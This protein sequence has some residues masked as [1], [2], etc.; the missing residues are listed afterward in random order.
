MISAVLDACVLYPGSL[1]DFLLHLAADKLVLPFWSEAIRDEWIENLLQKRPKLT[2]ESL[3][4]TRRMMDIHF[5]DSLVQEYEPLIEP[6]RLP[7]P[8]D[9]H[10]LAAAI[11]AGVSL[12][13]TRNLRDFP[14]AAL[15]PHSIEAVSPD[16]LVCRL[17]QDDAD[18]VV[19]AVIRHRLRLTRPHPSVTE[20]LATLELQGLPKTVAF[21]REHEDWI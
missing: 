7:D 2:R 10:V 1:R 20:Y 13:V 15:A 18:A 17:I 19:Q 8:K 12:I 3:E 4:R 16:E 5:P 6:L 14:R 21:L 9:K 11:K